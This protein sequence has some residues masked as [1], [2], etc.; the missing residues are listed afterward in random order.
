ML[1]LIGRMWEEFPHAICHAKRG[2]NYVENVLKFAKE[3]KDPEVRTA[4][5]YA[6]GTYLGCEL[7]P[8]RTKED[9]YG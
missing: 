3:D 2:G 1:I 7:D 9:C 6:I 5:I 4:A 8:E